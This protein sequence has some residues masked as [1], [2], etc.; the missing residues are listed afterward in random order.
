MHKSTGIKPLWK[1]WTESNRYICNTPNS[2]NSL[3]YWV[4]SCQGQ[5]SKRNSLWICCRVWQIYY[6]QEM[7]IDMVGMFCF[8]HNAV[9]IRILQVLINLGLWNHI[10]LE[11]SSTKMTLLLQTCKGG[12]SHLAPCSSKIVF[13]CSVTDYCYIN[14]YNN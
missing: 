5:K 1:L 10:Y 3:L 2:Q 12:S 9:L 13:I 7:C 14:L 11:S 8:F 6:K 4:H